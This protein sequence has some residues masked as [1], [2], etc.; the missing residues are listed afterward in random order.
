MTNGSEMEESERL[1]LRA[2]FESMATDIRERLAA[3]PKSDIGDKTYEACAKELEKLSDADSL[4]YLRSV[5]ESRVAATYLILTK[6]ISP[7]VLVDACFHLISRDEK[8]SR[9]TG[10]VGIG[11]CLKGTSDVDG[12]RILARIVRNRHEATEI[13]RGIRQP[14]SN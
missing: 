3:L 6:R 8:R 1:R 14:I 2:L 10:V 13:R 9:L 4:D 7:D 11:S 5:D 12:S